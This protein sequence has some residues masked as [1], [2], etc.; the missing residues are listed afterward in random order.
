MLQ[1]RATHGNGNTGVLANTCIGFSFHTQY[2]PLSGKL[3]QLVANTSLMCLQELAVTDL[4]F[5]S[6]GL[7]L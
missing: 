5:P 2:S 4:T 3:L 1:H 7:I 6:E